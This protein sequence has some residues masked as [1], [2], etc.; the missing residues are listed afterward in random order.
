MQ[1]IQSGLLIFD[2]EELL[3]VV[4]FIDEIAEAFTVVV[5]E[6][7]DDG[8]FHLIVRKLLQDITSEFCFELEEIL[9]HIPLIDDKLVAS[10]HVSNC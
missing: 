5:V 8:H 7:A 9:R 1:S 2:E 4:A 6:I 10:R 3:P